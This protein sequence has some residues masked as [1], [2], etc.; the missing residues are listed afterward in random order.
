MSRPMVRLRSLRYIVKSRVSPLKA[1]NIT[2]AQRI[3]LARF[4]RCGDFL[5]GLYKLRD[6]FAKPCHMTVFL[7]SESH[8]HCRPLTR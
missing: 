5:I 1:D 2:Y 4:L 7:G 6:G 3:Y 8:S